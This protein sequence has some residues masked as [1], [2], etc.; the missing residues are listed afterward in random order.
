MSEVLRHMTWENFRR[1]IDR[2]VPAIHR[3]AGLPLVDIFVDEKAFRIGL[4]TP[5]PGDVA[6]PPSPLAAV[7]VSVAWPGSIRNLEVSTSHTQLYPEFYSF[8]T[9]LADRIQLRGEAPVDAFASALTS[10]SDLLQPME[11]LSLERQLGLFAE[12]WVL[13][14]VVESRGP[15]ALDSWIGPLGEPH[16]YRFV[17]Q[18]LEVKA[19]ISPTRSHIIDGEHQLVSSPDCSLSLLSIQLEPAGTGGMSLADLVASVQQQ[20]RA[21]TPAARKFD[22][23][24]AAVG[25][26]HTD[27]G[28][29]QGR[30]QLRSA[31]HLVVVDDNCP[32]ITRADIEQ[33]NE[34]TSS[35][36]AD[37]HY[38]INVDGLG[39]PVDTAALLS[40]L[41]SGAD[42]SS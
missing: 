10:W 13:V 33:M 2:G 30:W 39:T 6:A 16:D 12:L 26:R 8:A 40:L 18:E 7:N 31:P 37:V 19:T 20:L 4:R 42:A 14:R 34:G 15:R 3:V 32:R 23:S 17:K 21:G 27:S 28:L 36:I 38:R 1:V 29:Y 5:L 22:D 41:S 25:Y 11:V 24:L 9:T 35:R